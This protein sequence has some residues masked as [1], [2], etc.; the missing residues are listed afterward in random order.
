MGSDLESP[1]HG[2]LA[3]KDHGENWG[4]ALEMNS[5]RTSWIMAWSKASA[6][7]RSAVPQGG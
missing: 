7:G 5:H 6:T 2:V 1:R 4:E 3:G